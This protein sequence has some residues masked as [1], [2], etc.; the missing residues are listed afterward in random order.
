VFTFATSGS[1][2]LHSPPGAVA[3]NTSVSPWHID[4][5]PLIVPASGTVFTVTCLVATCVPQ[6][7]S[8]VYEITV[9][10]APKPAT[11]PELLIDAIAPFPLVHVPPVAELLNVAV[12]PA[13]KA[14]APAISSGPGLTVTK[15]MLVQPV[16]PV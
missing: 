7:F 8:T 10:P 6:V 12:V 16:A 5:A 13:H 9:V 3:S 4:A 11:T 14:S 1:E 15:V 2:L